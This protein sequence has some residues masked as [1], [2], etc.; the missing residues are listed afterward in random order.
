MTQKSSYHIDKTRKF[1]DH[2]ARKERDR[3]FINQS[4]QVEYYI[5]S[6]YLNRYITS[7]KRGKILDAGGGPGRYTIYLAKKGYKLTLI[8][9]SSKELDLAKKEILKSKVGKNVDEIAQINILNLSSFPDD[10]F[11]STIALGG[12]F[13]H[14]IT[15]KEIQQSL[16]EFSRVTKKNGYIFISVMSRFGEIG[17]RLVKNPQ[18]VNTINKFLLDGIHRRRKTGEKTFTHFYTPLELRKTIEKN[19]LEIKN[20]ISTESIS[21]PLRQYV[22]N[23]PEKLFKEWLNIFIKLSEEQSLLGVSSHFMAIVKNTK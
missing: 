15:K 18:E 4:H 10:T 21:Y 7:F 6:Y 9:I 20:I 22:N 13:S 23:L 11:D 5:T 12:V 19:G 14:L 3:L 8:D 2:N 1:Y 17:N 16:S